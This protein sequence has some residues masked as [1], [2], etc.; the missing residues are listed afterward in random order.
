MKTF[1]YTE[2]KEK[3]TFTGNYARDLKEVKN[4]SF[5]KNIAD[6]IVGSNLS[7]PPDVYIDSPQTLNQFKEAETQNLD[8][9]KKILYDLSDLLTN[10][11]SKV[12][13]HK[14]MTENSNEK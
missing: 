1:E 12:L 14:E 13:L 2:N 3:K 10:F 4:K 9:T 6:Q 7:N 11:S 5:E 8:K